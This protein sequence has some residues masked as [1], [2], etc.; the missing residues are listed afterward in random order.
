[1]L[2]LL[3]CVPLAAAVWMFG[4]RMRSRRQLA[5]GAALVMLATFTLAVAAAVNGWAG[6]YD[7]TPFMI[8][9]ARLVPATA[10]AAATVPAVALPVTVFAALQESEAGLCRLMALLIAFVGFTEILVVAAD[11]VTLIIGWELVGGCAWA[12]MIVHWDNPK[13][14]RFAGESFLFTRAA[15]LGLVAAAGLA[16][17][18]TGGF[19]FAGLEDLH[20][21]YLQAF[22]AV[23]VAAAV[24][25]SAQLPTGFWLFRVMRGPTSGAALINSVAVVAA[26]VIVLVRLHPVLSK[27]AWLG[28]VLIGI[29]L[30]SAVLGG[31]VGVLQRHGKKILAASTTAHC[32]YMFAAIGAG[33]PGIGILH[34]VAH[35]FFKALMVLVGGLAAQLAGTR[36]IDRVQ[37]GR[38]LPV[39]ALLA[40]AGT[41]AVGGVPPLGA[42]RTKELIVA[43]LGKQ[44]LALP[45][46]ICSAG[47]LSAWY[48]MRLRLLEFGKGRP[49]EPRYPRPAPLVVIAISVLSAVTVGL[50][51]LWIPA[52]QRAAAR[53]LGEHF[54]ASSRW[55]TALSLGLIAVGYLAGWLTSRRKPRDE[56][57]GFAVEAAEWLQ[58]PAVFEQGLIRPLRRAARLLAAFDDRVVDAPARLVAHAARIMDR[59]DSADAH[60]TFLTIAIGAAAILLLLLFLT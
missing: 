44:G 29:G 10:F 6:T 3:P 28:P 22:C 20:G 35:A 14:V 38:I 56:E 13:E 37:M 57:R 17:A 30:S 45:I 12:L 2:W 8:L 23:V 33:F 24:I 34:L 31:L 11:L 50:C 36:L 5:A 9:Q 60:R 1:M 47:A 19:G 41:L 40:T 48:S 53:A 49:P 42:A 52:V 43:A 55:S 15:D 16:L 39:V 46:L 59:L 54:P 21:P 7:W 32:G 4:S 51:V 27:V 18:G 26:G 25:E 58:L